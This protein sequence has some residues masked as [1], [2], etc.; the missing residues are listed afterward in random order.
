MN[1]LR[2]SA[3][4]YWASVERIVLLVFSSA[5]RV[6]YGR[7]VSFV[8]SLHSSSCAIGKMLHELVMG[9]VSLVR[10]FSC[11]VDAIFIE[12]VD[13]GLETVC[14]VLAV[15]E[16]LDTGQVRQRHDGEPSWGIGSEMTDQGGQR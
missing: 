7:H 1:R 3:D 11:R 4:L 9:L 8:S 5:V 14:S 10:S 2:W 15:A 13:V 12:G 6:S 16:D